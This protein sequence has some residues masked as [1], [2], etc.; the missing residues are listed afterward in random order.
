MIL[1]H[2]ACLIVWSLVTIGGVGFAKIAFREYGLFF[3]MPETNKFITL[4]VQ[5]ALLI[6]LECKNIG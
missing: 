5:N 4:L 3:A 2:M 1:W 6:S